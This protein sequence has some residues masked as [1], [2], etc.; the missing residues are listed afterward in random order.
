MNNKSCHFPILR[1][2]S[3]ASTR[4]KEGI[5]GRSVVKLQQHEAK[6]HI[7]QSVMNIPR[8]VDADIRVSAEYISVVR[9]FGR[10]AAW[11]EGV[12]DY[13]PTVLS[14]DHRAGSGGRLRG[15]RTMNS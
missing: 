8:M 11:A 4:L 10:V 2:V 7:P 15:V 9:A 14:P 12:L 5:A 6:H 3:R 1:A 13:H